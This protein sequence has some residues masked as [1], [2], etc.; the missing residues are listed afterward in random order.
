MS[1]SVRDYIKTEVAPAF[2]AG[3]RFIPA[4]TI[5]STIT[6]TTV[7]LK[8]LRM[9]PLPE[10]P[11]GHVTNT[12]ILTVA[13]PHTTVETA[14]EALDTAVVELLTALDGHSSITWSA[15]DKVSVDGWLGWD[16]TL[17]VIT[18]RKESA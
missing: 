4:Q 2:P 12:V 1:G 6:T 16:I 11:V 15:A 3:W 17:T 13:D 8:H 7:I 14:E 18:S 5:P 9:E 10:A